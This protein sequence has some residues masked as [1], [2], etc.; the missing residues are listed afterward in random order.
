MFQQHQLPVISTK[1]ATI[2]SHPYLSGRELELF[3][4]IEFEDKMDRYHAF[5]ESNAIL[6]NMSV[7]K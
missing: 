7:R 2:A 1:T 6:K 3:G 4:N 5:F